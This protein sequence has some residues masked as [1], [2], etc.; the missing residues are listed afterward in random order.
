[1]FIARY[2][3][4]KIVLLALATVALVMIAGFRTEVPSPS[5]AI[6]YAAVEAK[7]N[8]AEQ[9]GEFI[10]SQV[11]LVGYI[12]TQTEIEIFVA[13]SAYIDDELIGEFGLFVFTSFKFYTFVFPMIDVVGA[14]IINCEQA[15]E[16][17]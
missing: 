14:S 2:S 6:N 13:Q 9:C 1:M 12:Q 4:L 16:L 7:N 3:Q 17:H 15:R 10:A 11:R 5:D 8:I